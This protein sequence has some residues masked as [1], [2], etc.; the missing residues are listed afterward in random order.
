MIQRVASFLSSVLSVPEVPLA[1]GER[2]RRET[3]DP[4]SAAGATAENAAAR[5]LRRRGYRILCRNRVNAIAELDIVARH[6]DSIVFVEV[7]ARRQKA[8]VHARDT[9]TL[10]KRRRLAR[11]AELFLRQHR[12]TSLHMRIYVVAVELGEDTSVASIEHIPN[13]IGETSALR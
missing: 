1:H 13:A 9:L 8:P 11:A 7:R 3:A 4:R 12:L 10:G 2:R 5:M 6:A